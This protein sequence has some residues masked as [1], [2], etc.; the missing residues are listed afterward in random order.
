MEPSGNQASRDVKL[1]PEFGGTEGEREGASGRS[2]VEEKGGL[3]E[4]RAAARG[5]E[6]IV[7]PNLFLSSSLLLLTSAVK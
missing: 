4:P 5:C 1:K 6:E 2:T 7:K 3:S